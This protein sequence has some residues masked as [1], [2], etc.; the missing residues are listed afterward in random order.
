MNYQ[1]IVRPLMHLQR[2]ALFT[3][4]TA[5]HHRMLMISERQR[6]VG[7]F[8]GGMSAGVAGI[9]SWRQ[10]RTRGSF[11]WHIPTC[12]FSFQKG[13]FRRHAAC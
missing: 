12:M 8:V 5:R 1:S 13:L 7:F 2:S 3:Q 11:A 6:S 10:S 4:R 9:Q